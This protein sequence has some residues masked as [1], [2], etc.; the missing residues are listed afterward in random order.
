MKVKTKLSIIAGSVLFVGL[1]IFSVCGY[2]AFS[3][4][5]NDLSNS[6]IELSDK[7]YEAKGDINS[8][9]ISTIGENVEIEVSKVKKVKITYPENVDNE[10]FKITESDDKLTVERKNGFGLFHILNFD[11]IVNDILSKDGENH[12]VRV[13]VP[14]SYAG[15]IIADTVSGNITTSELKKAEDL[16]LST[17]SGDISIKGKMDVNGDTMIDTTSGD[18]T[19]DKLNDDSSVG[20]D[21]TSGNVNLLSLNVKSDLNVSTVSGDVNGNTI[22]C[23]SVFVDTTSGEVTL[24]SQV[25][26]SDINLNTVSGGIKVSVPDAMADYNYQVDTTSGDTN[27]P[28]QSNS[29]NKKN[30]IIDTVSGDVDFAFGQK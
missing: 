27:I 6:N 20:I 29:S 5:K 21:T 26:D 12:S 7:V 2:F 18:I 9:D 28:N 23:N 19:I 14:E 22:K 1:V 10:K 30:I 13:E 8:L 17:T 15:K 3:K 24:T 4:A 11:E 25:V 16:N